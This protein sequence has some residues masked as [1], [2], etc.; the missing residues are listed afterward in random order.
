MKN[1]RKV[2]DP[3][4]KQWILVGGSS[5]GGFYGHKGLSGVFTRE[6]APVLEQWNTFLQKPAEKSKL[7]LEVGKET[8]ILYNENYYTALCTE[9]T[10]H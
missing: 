10:K 6:T 2:T 3:W 1:Q 7:Y 5:T 4:S 8:C 9:M